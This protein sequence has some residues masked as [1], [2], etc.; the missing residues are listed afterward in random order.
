MRKNFSVLTATA[1]VGLGLFL[2]GCAD[3]GGG[4]TYYPF[5][6][7]PAPSPTPSPEPSPTPEP[8]PEPSPTPSPEPGDKATLKVEFDIVT[9]RA[10]VPLEVA[11]YNFHLNI[12]EEESQAEE[13]IE[14]KADDDN[15][16]LQTVTIEDVDP[17]VDNV[18]VEYL[19]D[20]GKVIAVSEFPVELAAGQE[21]VADDF[22]CLEASRL[23]IS[24]NDPGFAYVG[25][26]MT[27][28]ASLI[29]GDE[30]SEE[31]VELELGSDEVTFELATPEIT[32]G[33]KQEGFEI[34][35][36]F[37]AKEGEAGVFT[38]REQG[39]DYMQATYSEDITAGFILTA[40][41]VGAEFDGYGFVLGLGD[42]MAMTHCLYAEIQVWPD[43]QSEYGYE[44]PI[45][46]AEQTFPDDF[47]GIMCPGGFESFVSG[48]N[49]AE[50]Y[51][52]GRYVKDD[53]SGL[54]ILNASAWSG[55]GDF[56]SVQQFGQKGCVTVTGEGTG[57]KFTATYD[58]Q[59]FTSSFDV[60]AAEPVLVPAE[61]HEIQVY[62]DERLKGE[63]EVTCPS[64]L[65]HS[66]TI[67]AWGGAIKNGSYDMYYEQG[68]TVQLY[69][70]G[71]YK[72]TREDDGDCY[73]GLYVAENATGVTWAKED[74][75]D[76]F[77]I[78]KN[79]V[80]SDEGS[81]R[82]EAASFSYS[83]DG[84]DPADTFDFSVWIYEEWV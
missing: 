47:I 46:Y 13:G 17:D 66:T 43:E 29:F 41:P 51:L 1:A 72:Y 69:P 15:P 80:V 31:A 61:K 8:S 18:L 27:F 16:N 63:A 75:V 44:Y 37:D 4:T 79:G 25:E 77:T 67:D 23:V 68:D 9:A 71:A 12:G 19:N 65:A 45:L 10:E 52:V 32:P 7:G 30:T 83:L 5:A 62:M 22:D 34:L 82:G 6:P 48:V 42:T 21:T 24:G 3:G 60:Y 54:A 70:A 53:Q 58:G 20:E 64:Y 55:E 33:Y 84:F 59:D 57:G 76:T 11:T 39:V 40:V 2:A 28:T 26:D 49:K 56:Y 36:C 35:H 14:K 50:Y 74:G 73:C 78:D 81:N 38:A